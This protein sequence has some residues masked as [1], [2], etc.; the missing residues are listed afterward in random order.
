MWFGAEVID[1]NEVGSDGEYVYDTCVVIRISETT[2]EVS[3]TK[4]IMSK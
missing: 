3:E 2:N 1:H 4:S